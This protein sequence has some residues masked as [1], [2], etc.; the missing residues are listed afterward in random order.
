[1]P[2][3]SCPWIQGSYLE[4]M[5]WLGCDGSSL[6]KVHLPWQVYTP[7]TPRAP[8]SQRSNPSATKAIHGCNGH[9]LSP[10]HGLGVLGGCLGHVQQPGHGSSSPTPRGSCNSLE[11]PP[12]ETNRGSIRCVLSRG[13]RW[14]ALNQNPTMYGSG[15]P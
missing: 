14:Y 5:T 13:I 11:T 4:P 8:S 2:P 12:N 6:G 9:S 15:T 10:W 7:T 3:H 1:M